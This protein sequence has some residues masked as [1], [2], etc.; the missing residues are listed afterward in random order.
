[1]H[2]SIPYKTVSSKSQG[3]SVRWKPRSP[4]ICQR[5]FHCN[6]Y[7]IK[8]SAIWQEQDFSTSKEREDGGQTAQLY[9]LNR[10]LKYQPDHW[11]DGQ[12]QRSI[13]LTAW[14]W[15]TE[16]FWPLH[17][18]KNWPARWQDSWKPHL[19]VALTNYTD[20]HSAILLFMN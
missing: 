13:L 19:E 6:I 7:I 18:T 17:N 12:G 4:S 10:L 15:R 8:S 14:G 5:P 3:A 9:A 1:M 16:N 20:I 2:R 11:Q